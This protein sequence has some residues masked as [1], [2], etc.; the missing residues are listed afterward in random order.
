MPNPDSLDGVYLL[1]LSLYVILGSMWIK[2]SHGD[3][4]SIPLP[5]GFVAGLLFSS[6]E[7]FQ[8]DRKIE[9]AVLLVAMLVGYFTPYG[10]YISW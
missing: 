4:L 1:K 8:I 9:Y 3:T 2:I 7:H 10:L 5:I 6:H